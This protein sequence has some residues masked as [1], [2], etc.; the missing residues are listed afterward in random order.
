MHIQGAMYK[1]QLFIFITCFIFHVLPAQDFDYGNSWYVSNSERPFIKLSVFEDGVYR[2]TPASL[3]SA[4]YNV[5][6]VPVESFQVFYRGEEIPI[7]IGT[8]N[9]SWDFIEF[10]GRRNDGLVDTL[11]YRDSF[12]RR[13]RSDLQP[14]L[15]INLFSDT[16]AYFL[17]WG[18]DPGKRYRGYINT[19]YDQFTAEPYYWSRSKFESHP[20]VRNVRYRNG[21]SGAGDPIFTLNTDFVMGEGYFYNRAFNPNTSRQIILSTPAPANNGIAS[22]LSTRVTGVS[23]GNHDLQVRLNQSSDPVIDSTG[24]PDRY[25]ATFS[26]IITDSLLQENSITFGAT[27]SSDANNNLLAWVS[28]LYPRQWD[29]Q[30]GKESQVYQWD[31][32]VASFLNI[33]QVQGMDSIFVYDLEN[34]I[35]SSGILSTVDTLSEARVIVGPGESLRSLYIATDQGVKTPIISESRLSQLNVSQGAEF[36]II[37][38]PSLKTSAEAYAQYRDT[39]QVNPLSAKVVYTDQIYDEFGYGSITPWAIKR[40]C[41]YALDHWEIKPRYFLLWGKGRNITRNTHPTMVP[42]FGYPASDYEFISH[43]DL[44]SSVLSPEA[45]IGRVNV[46]SNEEGFNYLNKVNAYEHSSWEP[47]MKKAVFLGGGSSLAEQQRIEGSLTRNISRLTESSYGSEVTYFQKR[48]S[49]DNFDPTSAPYHADIDNG[50]FMIHFF[51]HSQR[52]LL[53]VNLRNAFEYDNVGRYPMIVAMGCYGGDFTGGRSFGEA[54]IIQKDKGAIGYFANSS[55]GSIF[56]LDIYGNNFYRNW[57]ANNSDQSIGDIILQGLNVYSQ[58]YRDAASYNTGR[59]MN[60]QGDPAIKLY[61]PLLPDFKIESADIFFTPELFTARD[62]SFMINII[63]ENQARVISDSIDIQI[64]QIFP[65]GAEIVRGT[66]RFASPSL[67]DTVSAWI[68][69]TEEARAI[70]TN[71]F[72]VTLD[73][74]NQIDEYKE[75]NNIASIDIDI[76]GNL[77]QPLFPS[78][79]SIEGK[80]PVTLIASAIFTDLEDSIRY[81]FEIDTTRRFNSPIK[82][83]SDVINGSVYNG[84]WEVP[85]TLKDSTAYYWRVRLADVTPSIWQESS[86]TYLTG[87]SGWGQSHMQQFEDNVLNQIVTDSYKNTWEFE[88]RAVELIF[89]A[90]RNGPFTAFKNNRLVTDVPDRFYS[91]AVLIAVYDAVTFEPKT[92]SVL[93]G[94]G[95]QAALVPKELHK[96]RQAIQNAQPGDYVVIANTRNPQV[97]L[98]DEATFDALKQIGVSDQIR[99][100]KDG[101]P[102]LILGRKGAPVADFEIYEPNIGN[103]LE[104]TRLIFPPLTQGDIQTDLIGPALSWDQ[105]FYQWKYSDIIPSD[106][107]KCEIYGIKPE[108]KDTLIMTLSQQGVYAMDHIDAARYPYLKIVAQ[109]KDSRRNTPPQLKQW[110]VTYK[111][112]PDLIPDPETFLEFHSDTLQYGAEAKLSFAIRNL[113][114]TVTDSISVSFHLQR[115]D[116][117]LVELDTQVIPPVGGNAHQIICFN[118]P[119]LTYAL[120][121]PTTL[122]A[123]LNP[124]REQQEQYY[125]NNRFEKEFFIERDGLNPIIDVTIDGVRIENED[126]VSPRPEITI[127]IDDENPFIALSDSNSFELY[128]GEADFSF[129]LERILAQDDRVQWIPGKLPENKAYIKFFPGK[130]YPLE[131][132]MYLLRVQ[133]EDQS[134]NIAGD[135]FYEVSFQVE[136]ARSLTPV[137]NIPNPFSTFTRF[138]YTLTGEELPEVFKIHIYNSLGQKIKEIDLHELGEVVAGEYVTRY[139]W[140]GKDEQGNVLPSGLYLYYIEVEFTN[141]YD[142][143]ARH[144]EKNLQKGWGKMYI[145]R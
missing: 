102:L 134:G 54:W 132:K 128:F 18:G 48:G 73:Y 97:H 66:Y 2:V 22:V 135:Q 72:E 118:I 31:K 127:Q 8:S 29:W 7:F 26:T 76:P 55:A 126:L 3:N 79:L 61:N 30:G 83:T 1:S 20:T 142:Y 13:Q 98:W 92:D 117:S 109:V 111:P 75:D 77:A 138:T 49:S 44:N 112:I 67:K 68:Y 144:V 9:G 65:D 140:E 59:Q 90:R 37:A 6:S 50:V 122:I 136:N 119:T 131:D 45:A 130:D 89:K 145:A 14:D 52:N 99:L 58:T 10:V 104:I 63:I 74:K 94:F 16:S 4:G 100:L 143:R 47:W 36:V 19:N 121:G 107:M 41:K 71:S 40:F 108:E 78:F 124:L 103:F 35:R 24:I 21:G 32:E 84:S 15:E 42:T 62:D 82:L 23:S 69:N 129:N 113:T 5:E 51:G 86:F 88:T 106:S 115:S 137:L 85:I 56:P 11:L 96:L 38:H 43:F 120:P 91:N 70:G 93:L 81:I 57:L 28:I 25:I 34:H 87:E 27:E 33:K 114:A 64:N 39:L 53:D 125:F 133:A 95:F 141:G 105:F 12:T 110:Y 80:Q 101:D 139:K 116:R 60:F 46:Y 123:E 17:T